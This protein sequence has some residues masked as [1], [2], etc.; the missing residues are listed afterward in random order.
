[1]TVY[2][3]IYEMIHFKVKMLEMLGIFF[4]HLL[5]Q[6]ADPPWYDIAIYI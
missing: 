1:M 6:M 3:F 5:N 2:N 4:R